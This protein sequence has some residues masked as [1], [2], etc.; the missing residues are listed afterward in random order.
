MRAMYL[1]FAAAIVI[2]PA[3][4]AET[5]TDADRFW[6]HWRGPMN[7][8]VSPEGDPPIE[9]S[10]GYC[11]LEQERPRTTTRCRGSDFPDP[12]I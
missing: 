7:T 5:A 10:E 1:V 11:Q 9:W 6:P 12:K 3:S 2:V 4:W 8:G